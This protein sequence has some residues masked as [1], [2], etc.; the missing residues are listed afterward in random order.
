[1]IIKRQL[2][3]D[4]SAWMINVT[5]THVILIDTTA[6]EH[7]TTILSTVYTTDAIA[8]SSYSQNIMPYQEIC[9]EPFTRLHPQGKA[10]VVA[11]AGIDCDISVVLQN[12]GSGESHYSS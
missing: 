7:T 9:T 12:S 6:V 11:V 5:S 10:A 8:N 4:K 3:I 2:P 1:M